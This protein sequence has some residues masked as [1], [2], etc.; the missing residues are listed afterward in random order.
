MQ[1]DLISAAKKVGNNVAEIG[2]A[3]TFIQGL[4]P[5]IYAYAVLGGQNTT[6]DTAIESAKR[7]ELAAIGQLQQIMIPQNVNQLGLQNVGENVYQK[8]QKEKADENSIEELTKQFK[9][10]K[11]QMLRNSNGNR[12][13]DIRNITCWRC[14]ERGHYANNCENRNEITCNNCGKE[15]HIERNC[16]NK[17]KEVRF[18]RNEGNGRRNRKLNC[19]NVI[20][21]KEETSESE[22]SSDDKYSDDEKKVFELGKIKERDMLIMIMKKVKRNLRKS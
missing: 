15:G 4:L 11:I 13:Q 17:E 1:H 7:A 18:E 10:F 14:N 6:M 20:Y 19:L 8:L 22:N 12:R 3:T 21:K 2:K 16:R 5:A 9:D